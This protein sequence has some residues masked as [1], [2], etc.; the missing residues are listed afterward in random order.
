MAPVFLSYARNASA[1]QANALKVA[2]GDDAFLD[3][4][5]IE[6]G[7]V[8]PDALIEAL[9]SARVVVLLLSEAYFTREYCWREFRGAI[10][11]LKSAALP[12][13]ETESLHHIVV[14]LPLGKLNLEDL[15]PYL[16]Q[17]NWPT[18][19]DTSRLRTLILKRLKEVPN[20][21][22]HRL[23]PNRDRVRNALREECAL[24]LPR[25]IDPKTPRYCPSVPV[26]LGDR[27][28][29]RGLDLWRI[30]TTLA[31]FSMGPVNV[32]LTGSVEGLAGV[33][34]SRIT[35]EYI[36]RFGSRCFPGGIFWL[37]ADATAN[38]LEV[39]FHGIL[40]A[41]RPETTPDLTRFRE[42]GRNARSE[43]GAAFDTLDPRRPALLVID[44]VPEGG[45]SEPPPSLESF[46]PAM[47]RISVLATSR[48]RLS[49]TQGVL[50]I[51]LKPLSRDAAVTLLT[52]DVPFST[53][54][55][56]YRSCK[57]VFF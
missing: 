41:L 43:L 50:G 35:A 38:D 9:L 56:C 42:S 13:E 40:Q 44:N 27:F 8:F 23:G 1:A 2:L 29:G 49:T 22:G 54:D 47:G 52:I 33:G 17:Q 39:Q 6:D 57:N 18:V 20:T 36:H 19:D 11:P 32:A 28:V 34:K 4:A 51:D 48:Q 21:L 16:R 15:P 24:P 12:S 3:S 46:C 31:P 30:H 37:S 5:G 14:A 25:A 45:A 10:S 26:S 7:A 53:L 55:P